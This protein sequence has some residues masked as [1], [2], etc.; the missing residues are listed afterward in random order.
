[1]LLEFMQ[2]CICK[3]HI[4]CLGKSIPLLRRFLFV[5]LKDIYLENLKFIERWILCLSFLW[6]LDFHYLRF[7]LFF[8]PK[9]LGLKIFHYGLDFLLNIIGKYS[10][11]HRAYLCKACRLKNLLNFY[12]KQTQS[13][14]L[15]SQLHDQVW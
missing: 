11:N 7:A 9:E 3:L 10:L 12:Q 2:S 6:C 1:M 15:N 13:F 5:I 4:G 8:Y 14:L